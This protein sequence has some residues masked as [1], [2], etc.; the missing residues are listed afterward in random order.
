MDERHSAVQTPPR[1]H[2]DLYTHDQP[3]EVERLIELGATGHARTV[4]ISSPWR[5]PRGIGSTSCSC[6]ESLVPLWFLESQASRTCR[7]VKLLFEHG[8]DWGVG[9]G[10]RC[11]LC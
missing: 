10:G 5:I 7:W 8:F 6:A 3:G 9:G 11:L 1:T 4:P 2:L